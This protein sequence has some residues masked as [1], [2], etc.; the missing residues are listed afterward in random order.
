MNIIK[1]GYKILTE[2]DRMKILK[3]IERIGRTCYKS[4]LN[5]TECSCNKFVSMLIRRGHEAMIEHESISVKFIVDRGVSH[6]LVRHRLASFA[7]ESS[8]YCNYS[9]EKFGNEIT[10]ILPLFFD[11]GMGAASNSDVYCEWKTSCEYA[12]RTYFKL[13]KYG[14]KPEE[15]RTV[16]PNSLKTEIVMTANLREWRHFF[17]LRAAPTAHPQMR[18]VVIPLLIQLKNE[19]PELF[20]DIYNDLFVQIERN[21]AREPITIDSFS[22][23]KP[24]A[25]LDC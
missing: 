22:N 4:E 23:N 21:E 25:R 14:A 6:E 20:E 11:T 15:A 9:K 3:S 12:E 24:R 18:E 1:P 2:I 10:V 19:L 16:L 7:Q 17:K 13:L 8:R 5:I